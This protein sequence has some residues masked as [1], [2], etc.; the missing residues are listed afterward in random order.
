MTERMARGLAD[1]FAGEPVSRMPITRTW[2]ILFERSDGRL[3]VIED[4]AGWVCC[5]REAYDAYHQTGDPEGVIEARE[6]TDWGL[7]EGW[8]RTIAQLIDGEAHQSGG[9]V[10]VV[11]YRHPHGRFVVIGADRADLYSSEDHAEGYHDGK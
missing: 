8:A 7:T 9:N 2:G 5:D 3:A 11:L 10:W 4:H 6:W 1:A